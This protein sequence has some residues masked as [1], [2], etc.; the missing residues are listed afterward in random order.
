LRKAAVG[1][2]IQYGIVFDRASTNCADASYY[3]KLNSFVK[4]KGASRE[5]F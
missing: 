5:P 3:G 4:A 2:A 1:E